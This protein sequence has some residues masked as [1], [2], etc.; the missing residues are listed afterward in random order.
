[1][2]AS[3]RANANSPLGTNL[4]GITDWS[5]DFPFVDAL[6]RSREWISSPVSTWEDHRP[7]PLDERGNPRALA[8]G[9]RARSLIWWEVTQYPAGDY[10][11]LYDGVG[12]LS[13]D[14]QGELVHKAPGREVVHLDPKKGFFSLLIES[15]KPSDPLR[16]VHVLMPGGV[17]DNDP[18]RYCDDKLP[19]S[20]APCRSFEQDH[21]SQIFHPKF[22]ERLQKFSVVRFMDWMRTNDSKEKKWADRPL[23]TDARF[24][25]G[26]PVET[27]VA[28]ANRLSQSP[29]FNIPHAADDD[30][31]RRFAT[32][33]RD[34]LRS[35]LKAYV[36]YSNEVW[37][38]IFPQASYVQAQGKKLG[39]GK[40]DWDAQ[41]RYH[42]RRST[43]VMKIWEGV[44]KGQ[45]QRLVRVLGTQVAN[46]GVA[47]GL[48][49]FEDAAQHVDVLAVAPYFGGEYASPEEEKR[50]EKATVT[51]VID[52][53]HKRTLPLC[54][55][56]IKRHAEIAAKYKLELVA[57]EGGESF[58]GI[59]G[60]ENNA[61]LNKLLDAVG[62]DPRMKQ[63]YLDYLEGWKN[64]G[65]KLFVHFTDVF[66][67]G[68]YGRW[69]ALEYLEQPRAQAP[70]FDA[71]MT[72]IETHPRW[73]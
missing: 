6:K 28:L 58:A 12:T 22:L 23:P 54:N 4:D 40:S 60:T 57:Y 52:D 10:V 61:K 63:V 47:E 25:D 73:W 19:C 1:M 56:F 35:D 36:E 43:E 39:L 49:S 33:V 64:N 15:I 42:A 24:R 70:K 14:P 71:L 21:E 34:H 62:R 51:E 3:V 17:C 59:A 67:P 50:W 53:I 46:E 30:Y 41:Y 20:G 26:A 32:Y 66:A 11:V 29:W 65:G 38:G 7:I 37:N 18:V 69:G 45:E 31:V 72:F 16:N 2:P 48:L 68:K 27:M 8:R 9:Q 13:Y 5:T 44:F 55:T